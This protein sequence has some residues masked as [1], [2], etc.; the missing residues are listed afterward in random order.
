MIKQ[1][2]LLL[3]FLLLFGIILAKLFSIQIIHK[4]QLS[5]DNYLKTK[6]I[7]PERGKIFDFNGLPLAVNKTSYLLFAEPKKMEK[8][9]ELIE[10]LEPILHLGV[11]SL[12]SKLDT[13]KSWVPIK[14]GIEYEEKQAILKL[15]LEGL[16]FEDQ[17]KRYYPEGSLAAHLIGFV[18]KNRDGENTGYFGIE[19]FYNKDLMGLPGVLKSNRDILGNP[20]LIGTQQKLDAE[21]GRDLYLTID[22]SVQEIIKRKLKQ[23]LKSY[24][25][26]EG[27]VIVADPM[28]L[29]IKALSCLPD[30][31]MA[32]Y[33]L[34]S[35][36]YFKNPAISNLYEPGSTFKPFIMA[37]AINEKRIKPD[38]FYIEEGPITIGEYSIRTWN[39]KYEGKISL[40]R[41]LEKSSNV[42]IVYVGQKL[43]EKNIYSYLKQ[44]GFGESTDIDLQGEVA[45]TLREKDNWY[46]IDYATVTFGQ[47]IAVTPIQMIRAFSSLVNG[48]ELLKPRVIS[49]IVAQGVEKK[50]NRVVQK[51]VVDSRTSEIIKKMLVSTVENG[52]IKWAKP[53]GYQIGGK[54]GTAQIP[55]KG[56]YDTTKT[57]ASFIGFAPVNEPKFIAIVILQE[58]QTSPWGSETA[59]P[60]FFEIAK[61]LFVYYNIVP[62]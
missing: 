50:T 53:K 25:A 10:K 41:I 21:N 40:T 2:T 18:G 47:G 15:G 7:T 55:I 46:P 37:A 35:E 44:F 31:D 49:K 8:R 6:K 51:H 11:A 5:E 32:Q 58:P 57:I 26:K 62:E 9:N 61:E 30:F 4:I 39:N 12:E 28:S 14:N 34:F 13:S 23:G 16:G 54:T 20:I 33:F 24:K 36:M 56:H 43:G 38:D 42:G 22:K 3:F 60:L 19:G 1:K 45:V 59:G 17:S 52:E 48:G 27:C 29:E